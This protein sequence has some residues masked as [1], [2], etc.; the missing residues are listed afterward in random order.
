[1]SIG[2][3]TMG[4][5]IVGDAFKLGNTHII[6]DICQLADEVIEQGGKIILQREYTNAPPDILAIFTTVDEIHSW[7]E[8]MNDV[9]AEIGCNTK[10]K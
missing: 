8:R 10:D 5:D 2:S 3:L 1:M 7:R 4:F 9:H 6:D